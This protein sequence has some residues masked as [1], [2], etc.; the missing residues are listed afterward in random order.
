MVDNQRPNPPN[1]HTTGYPSM[2]IGV[3][4]NHITI[5]IKTDYVL[6]HQIS[7]KNVLSACLTGKTIVSKT[8]NI[9]DLWLG[10]SWRTLKSIRNNELNLE[11][12]AIWSMHKFDAHHEVPNSIYYKNLVLSNELIKVELPPWKIWKADVSSVSPLSER[13]AL[14]LRRSEFLYSLRRRANARNVSFLNLSRC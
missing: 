12:K 6:I 2:V 1:E 13:I 5:L 9:I 10:N 4:L 8:N 3:L 11:L 7:Y 14:A